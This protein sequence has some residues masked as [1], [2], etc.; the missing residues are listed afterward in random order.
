MAWQLYRRH[1]KGAT[2]D[3]FALPGRDIHI[4]TH[5]AL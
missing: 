2:P 5:A 3:R 4:A 1:R